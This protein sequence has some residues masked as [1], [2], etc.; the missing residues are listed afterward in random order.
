MIAVRFAVGTLSLLAAGPSLAQG[1]LWVVDGASGPGF[2]FTDIQSAVDAASDGDTIVVRDGAY[3]GFTIDAKSLVVTEA[4]GSF[5]STADFTVINLAPDQEVTVRGLNADPI[6][7]EDN[8]GA[9]FL[10]SIGTPFPF[11][12]CSPSSGGK[13]DALTVRFCETVVA[14]RCGFSGEATATF[15]YDGIDAS[16]SNL[17][18]FECSA[19]GGMPS[20]AG[21]FPGGVGARITNSF[22]FASGCY[23]TGGC[24]A[25]GPLCSRGGSGGVGLINAVSSVHLL[26]TELKGG[27]K[28]CALEYPFCGG[29]GG[30]GAAS[31]GGHTLLAGFARNFTLESPGSGGQTTTLS[32]A[33]VA[34]DLVFALVGFELEALFAPDLAGTLVLPIPPLLLALGS[35]DATGVLNTEVALPPLPPGTGAFTVYSQGAAVSPVGAA[36]LA[37][38]S[39]LTIL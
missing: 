29:C 2:D 36:V 24:G 9:V 3:P 15:G 33:G 11:I 19:E 16:G 32:Y 17:Y 28:G 12:F 26:E 39:Q 23:I 7:L 30:T 21:T 20:G 13:G 27:V 37:A 6:L 1:Q 34:G 31:T 35:A 25:D 22:L 38:P 8:E 14:T 10:E 4:A 18:L 5:T